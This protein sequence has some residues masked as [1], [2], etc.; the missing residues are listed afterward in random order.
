MP[1]KHSP[2]AQKIRASVRFVFLSVF[3]IFQVGIGPSSSHTMGPML[4]AARFLELCSSSRLPDG[5]LTLGCRLYGSLAYTG[6]GHGTIR[7]V[8]CGL[9]GMLPASYDRAEA[10]KRLV[11]LSRSETVRLPNG[12]V[13]RL[14]LFAV[15][16]EKGKRLPGHPNGMTFVL[17][18]ATGHDVLTENYFSIGGGFVLPDA[19][20]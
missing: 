8:L 2:P 4:A 20:L 6:E 17:S 15:S 16:T 1:I 3:D 19:E 18:D 7:A 14:A 5:E 10:D 11:E 13:V 9:L 12:R